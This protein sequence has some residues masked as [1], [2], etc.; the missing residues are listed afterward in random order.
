MALSNP[1]TRTQLSFSES[2]S[3]GQSDPTSTTEANGLNVSTEER[4]EVK[5]IRE[6][7]KKDTARIRMGRIVMSLALLA[8]SLAVTLT[9]FKFL[10]REEDDKF[11]T[12]VSSSV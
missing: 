3:D 1:N 9:S 7:S 6:A 5:E 4:D 2:E 11:K 10:K 8:T 12:A